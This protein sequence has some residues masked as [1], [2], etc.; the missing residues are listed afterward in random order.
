MRAFLRSFKILASSVRGEGGWSTFEL[1]F[2]ESMKSSPEL[3]LELDG[4]ESSV[5][6]LLVVFR[7]CCGSEPR[8]CE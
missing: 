2:F 1:V 5:V 4:C 8:L 6:I 7:N 3:E